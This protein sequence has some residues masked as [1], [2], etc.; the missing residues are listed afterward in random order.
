[1][2]TGKA[3]VFGSPFKELQRVIV[4]EGKRTPFFVS[5]TAVFE[6]VLGAGA[7]TKEIMGNT[8]PESW[9]KPVQVILGLEKKPVVILVL[10]AVD[11]GKSSFCTY[12]LNK[13]VEAKRR[14]AVLDGDLGQSDIGPCASVGYAV[15]AKPIGELYDL[16]Y[17]NGYFIGATSPSVAVAKTLEGLKTMM[18]ETI[19]RHTDAILINTDGFVVGNDAIRY[20]LNLVRELKPDIVVG[21]QIQNELEELMSY[22]GG[23]GVLTVGASEA[24]NVRSREKR[25]ILREMSYAKYLR[26]SKL[27]CYPLSQLTV[28]PRNAVPKTQKPE[29]GVLVGLYG[30]GNRFLGIGILR[31]INPTRRTLKVQTAVITKPH[32]LIIGKVFLNHKLQE[33]QQD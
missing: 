27:Q 24:L 30:R 20:K 33:T 4:R 28:E 29:K 3:E 10:G 1:L 19:E 8:V 13:M 7:T 31:A 5:E 11:T 14:V 12:I 26:N 21:V 23:G 25:K 15:T 17:Q 9:N 32:R 2:L 6:V 16:R 18:E 22:L